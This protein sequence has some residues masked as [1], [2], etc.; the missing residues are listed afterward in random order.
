MSKV[1]ITGGAGFI[2]SQL[3]HYLDKN[4]YDVYLLDNMKHGHLDNLEIDGSSF[5]TLINADIRDKNLT[6]Y[7]DEMDY[8]VH[9][10]G[11]SS[12]PLC[13]SNP[14]YAMDVNVGGTANVL[15]SCRLSGVKRVIFASTGALYENN[16][17]PPFKESDTVEPF[18][19]YPVSKYQAEKLCESYEL[20]YWMDIVRLRFFNVYG[21]HQDFKRKQPPFTGY[22]LK[23][24][25]NKEGINAFSDGEQQRAYV[26]INDL[27]KLI[28]ICMMHEHAKN[29]IF[30]AC[31]GQAYS[32]K[33]IAYTMMN[34]FGIDVPVGFSPAETYWD[35]HPILHEGEF[36]IRRSVVAQE[37]DKYC[38]G[39]TSKT[40]EYLGWE[41]KVSLEE[42]L[43]GLVDYAR[44]IS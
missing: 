17:E 22:L 43:K 20:C 37:V 13:Q 14:M 21:P 15:D 19:I 5:G 10:A 41:A 30:N 42:G 24:F 29:Q 9:L 32:V 3:G 26:H 7:T 44:E 12:L 2:G 27:T 23:Q 39:D 1:L 16:Y 38:L 31:S 36:P 28:E 6:Q 8:V 4:G 11:L 25:M 34:L 33:Q 35:N 18:L 40:K